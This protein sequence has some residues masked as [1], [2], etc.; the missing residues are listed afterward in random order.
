MKT[1]CQ[2]AFAN[3]TVSLCPNASVF[4]AHVT[5]SKKPGASWGREQLNH[6]LIVCK[7]LEAKREGRGHP[8]VSLS[9]KLQKSLLGMAVTG[10]RLLRCLQIVGTKSVCELKTQLC[11]HLECL[12]RKRYFPPSK[13]LPWGRSP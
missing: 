13:Q 12:L 3:S 9:Q 2:P 8:H 6:E 1:I 10:V 4:L 5:H 11:Q 7:Y